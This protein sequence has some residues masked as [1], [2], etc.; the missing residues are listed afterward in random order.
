MR[1]SRGSAPSRRGWPSATSGWPF[2]TPTSSTCGS[3][4]LQSPRGPPPVA[5]GE[6]G[7]PGN[8]VP[9]RI[10]FMLAIHQAEAMVGVLQDLVGSFQQ[11]G[12]LAAILGARSPGDVR[13]AF[14]QALD[15]GAVPPS[16]PVV[17]P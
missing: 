3:R 11:P 1:W 8:T 14:G 10:V 12:A 16:G 13:A 5:F 2:R 4:R 7:N 15:G 9:V 17:A 6:M